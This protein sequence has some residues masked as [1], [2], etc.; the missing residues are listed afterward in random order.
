[1]RL[2]GWLKDLNVDIKKLIYKILNRSIIK[3]ISSK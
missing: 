1:M 2:Y 3:E